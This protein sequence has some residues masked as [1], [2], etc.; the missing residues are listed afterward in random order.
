MNTHIYSQSTLIL[1]GL[2]GLSI[3]FALMYW[4]Y[5]IK[6]RKI[7]EGFCIPSAPM[8][9][10]ISHLLY[11]AAKDN[12]EC[13]VFGALP[14]EYKIEERESKH[15]LSE[16]DIKFIKDFEKETQDLINKSPYFP[17]RNSPVQGVPIWFC[18]EGKC[19]RDDCIPLYLFTSVIDCFL[20]FEQEGINITECSDEP[21]R[22]LYTIGMQET[23]SYSIKINKIEKI[24]N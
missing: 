9:R 13:I 21:S 3:G 22:I 10:L 15:K 1:C 4:I 19:Y 11:N 14:E 23:Y 17:F 8:Q 24:P 2:S 5:R 12:A 18:S 7:I 20:H 16:D 6:T